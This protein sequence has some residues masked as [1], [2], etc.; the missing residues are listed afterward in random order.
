MA[1]KTNKIIKAISKQ[2][3]NMTDDEKQIEFLIQ[4]WVAA[5]EEK[6]VIVTDGNDRFY[7]VGVKKDIPEGETVSAKEFYDDVLVH[8][9]VGAIQDGF[10]YVI[11]HTGSGGWAFMNAHEIDMNDFFVHAMSRTDGVEFA[12]SLVDVEEE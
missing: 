2:F 7:F 6:I 11:D 10:V 4:A 12:R 3:P 8:I 5:V 9:L 1:N